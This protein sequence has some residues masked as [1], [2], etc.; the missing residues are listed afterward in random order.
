MAQ[1][2]ALLSCQRSTRRIVRPG[3]GSEA[4]IAVGIFAALRQAIR[5]AD[6]ALNAEAVV[7]QPAATAV[8]R[9]V[10]KASI[11]TYACALRL[12]S[13]AAGHRYR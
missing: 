10:R 4:Q 9:L 13:I 12:A 6:I 3:V 8:E 2:V 5:K 1:K 7:V 11:D